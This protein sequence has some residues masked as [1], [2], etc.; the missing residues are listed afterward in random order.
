MNDQRTP[1]EA[2]PGL[3]DR[4]LRLF[5]PVRGG[6]GGVVLLM[7][8]N[9]FVLMTAYYII[10]PVREALIL[11]EWGA[12]AK[13]YASAGQALLLL[14]VVPLY[15]RLAGLM[16]S[17]RLIAS[18]LVFFAGC[19]VVFYALA[20]MNVSLGIPFFL[21]VGIFNMMVVAQ[22]WSFANDF[23]T[24]EQGKRLFALVGFGMSA[25]AVSGSF[26]AG[27]LIAP[28]GLYQLMLLSAALL[29]L[30]LAL[31]FVVAGTRSRAAQVGAP[32]A[33][34]VEDEPL[35]GRSGFALV[36]AN[37]Y[38]LLIA[39]MM[40]VTNLVNTTGEYVLGSRV[41]ADRQAAVPEVLRDAAMSD[42]QYLMAVAARD[43]QVGEAIGAFYAD[44]FS[45]VNIT[46][47]LAQLFLVARLVGWIGVHRALLVLPLLA[48]GGYVLMALFP[49]LGMARWAK[50]A[51]NATD[52]SLQNTV[53][54]ML[55][56]PTTRDEKYQAKQA[57]DSFFVRMG[58]VMAAL[59]VL[60]GTTL[61]HLTPAKFAVVNVGLGLVWVV[62]A[63]AIGRRYQAL[64]R[65]V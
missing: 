31:T 8:L 37:R 17:R 63:V 25:G 1:A 61:V 52:Y 57:I 29:M 9:I 23:Y 55:F 51:E 36:L 65:S 46:G 45:I 20:R 30:S 2:A 42:D 32:Q 35:S 24:P 50:T 5:A 41:T 13:I 27:R 59:L 33:A 54:N 43:Q 7:A 16:N 48:T 10:K 49:V 40:I 60:A 62:L 19:L 14:G 47:L 22:F 3:I 18:V 39:L 56:L 12:E 34:V 15:S 53:R 6:E 58:D 44:F 4:G 21:W 64:T 28:L 38:L 26:I 11:A